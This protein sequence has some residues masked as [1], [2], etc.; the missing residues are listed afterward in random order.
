MFAGCTSLETAPE[1]LGIEIVE[2]CYLRMFDGCESL[3][4]VKAHF[5]DWEDGLGTWDW[6]VGV[7]KEGNFYL[8]DS[9]MDK[10]GDAWNI[11]EDWGVSEFEVED[12][13]LYDHLRN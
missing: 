7:A 5:W 2:Y 12:W 3:N 6:L 1:L 10:R 9:T 11:P 4:Y 13:S 8:I